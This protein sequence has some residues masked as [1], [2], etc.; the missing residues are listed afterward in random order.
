MNSKTTSIHVT[1]EHWEQMK[2]DVSARTS[3]EACGL[4]LGEDNCSKQVIP[5][6][7]IFHNPF[8]FRMDPAEELN[9]FLLAEEKGWEILAVYHSHPHGI[10]SPSATD[11]SELAFSEIIYLIWYQAAVQWQCRGYLMHS[12]SVSERVQIVIST[13]E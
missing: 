10:H 5:I 9:A 6:T 7:N 4:V 8:R 13:N 2:A 3:E 11:Y 1:P 12:N